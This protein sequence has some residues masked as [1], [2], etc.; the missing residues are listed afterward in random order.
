MAN[1]KDFYILDESD[2]DP[3]RLKR[4]RDKARKLKKSQWWLSWVNR[5]I[6]HYCQQK[7]P[8]S[9]LTMDHIV[10][11]ARGGESSRG[12]IVPSCQQCNR[13]KKL[14]TPVDQ[15]LKELRK[16]EDPE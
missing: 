10:P 16:D 3:K 1:T 14:D 8:P 11:L 2:V 12:N 13:G 4:E 15:I 6:C 5:G 9:K 7:F